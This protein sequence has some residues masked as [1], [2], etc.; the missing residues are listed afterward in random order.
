MLFRSSLK[1]LAAYGKANPDK[2]S[3]GT[4]GGGTQPHMVC[5]ALANAL[6]ITSTSVHYK[7]SAT[8]MADLREG[9]I[10]M[11]S[12]GLNRLADNLRMIA[13]LGQKRAATLPALQTSFEQGYEV[14]S[15]NWL[16]A[17]APPKTP[18]AI[19]NRLNQELVKAVR[20][21]D[22]M[23]A[24]EKIEFVPVGSSVEEFRTKFAGEIVRWQKVVRDN[25]I[26]AGE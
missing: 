7:S 26:S 24:L 1:D 5:A 14:D 18:P 23:A 25:R 2:L 4:T 9:R 6:G 3:C 20:A 8:I 11:F 16:G 17:F 15:P 12:G 13:I 10:S 19:V 22:V 21:P